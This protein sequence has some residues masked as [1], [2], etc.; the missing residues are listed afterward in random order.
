VRAAT[1]K[2]REGSFYEGFEF[3]GDYFVELERLTDFARNDPL[4]GPVSVKLKDASIANVEPS[5][6]ARYAPMDV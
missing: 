2:S 1:S 4:F 3:S 6:S 5:I